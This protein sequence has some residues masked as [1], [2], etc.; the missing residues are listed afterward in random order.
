MKNVLLLLLLAACSDSD[1]V[2]PL[3]SSEASFVRGEFVEVT[4][5]DADSRNESLDY[6][7][8]DAREIMDAGAVPVAAFEV[9]GEDRGGWVNWSDD[10]L[11]RTG[12]HYLITT[13]PSEA[14]FDAAATE[15][16]R[17]AERAGVQTSSTFGPIGADVDYTFDPALGYEVGSGENTD[18]ALAMEFLGLVRPMQAPWGV[19]DILGT[20]GAPGRASATYNRNFLVLVEWASPERF[21]EHQSDPNSP[22]NVNIEM[23]RRFVP[24]DTLEITTN[25]FLVDPC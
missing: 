5:I 6:L 1:S 10:A 14:A 8:A 2:T 18:P 23:R 20:T 4:L 15:R 24:E 12:E 22:V 19:F 7:C 25:F 3:T 21:V 13:W 11:A 9:F 16:S 17:R